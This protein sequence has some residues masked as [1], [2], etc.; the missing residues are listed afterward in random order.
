ME[1]SE[2]LPL[3]PGGT[4]SAHRAIA[5]LIFLLTYLC[6]GYFFQSGQHNEAARFD[7]VRAIVEFQALNIER[8][9]MNTADVI[10]HNGHVYPNKAPGL[11]YLSVPVWI[12]SYWALASVGVTKPYIDNWTCY[13]VSWNT[14]GLAS[15]I[16][17]T[18][19]YFVAFR[20]IRS[21]YI[22]MALTLAYAIGTIAF[23]FSTL[24]FSHQFCAALVLISFAI[25]FLRKGDPPPT[26][27]KGEAPYLLSG[28]LLS[29]AVASEYPVVLAAAP[30]ALYALIVLGFRRSFW[31]F[32]L[33]NVVGIAILISYNF[34]AF[35]KLYYIP[36]SSY[37]ESGEV[38]E[39]HKKGYMGVGKPTLNALLEI[40]F[41]VQRGLF[42]V[43]PWLVLLLPALAAPAFVKPFRKELLLSMVIVVAFF[44]FN[45][46]Y[47]DSIVFWGGGASVGPR[48]IIPMLPFAAILIAPLLKIAPVR[49]FFYPLALFS[50]AVMIVA[51]AVEPRVPYDY[52]NPLIDLFWRDYLRGDFASFHEGVFG[53]TALTM[54]TVAFNLG[55]LIAI[56]GAAQLFPILF[57]IFAGVAYLVRD[58]LVA[59]GKIGAESGILR[60]WRTK[61]FGV[62]LLVFGAIPA[63]AHFRDRLVR[64]TSHGLMAT[65]FKGNPWPTLPK[66]FVPTYGGPSQVVDVR[67]DSQ[68]FIPFEEGRDLGEIAVEWS[69][70]IIIETEGYYS[71]AAESDDGSAVY[72]NDELILDNWG[73]HGRKVERTN[74]YLKAGTFPFGVRYYNTSPGGMMALLWT[75]PIGHLKVIPTRNFILSSTFPQRGE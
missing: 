69:G 6:Y 27:L 40:T 12:V 36:Y 13:L 74:V 70:S 32:A 31:I 21:S 54:N 19:L 47:G 26:S 72:L 2:K 73:V 11:T 56:P 23:P 3:S 64:P 43:N 55:K 28:V 49:W 59:D 48:H 75:E 42:V 58:T 53:S 16:A 51:T 1:A 39:E 44:I 29:V 71:F 10:T 41:K 34:L 37:A 57:L 9:A 15:A 14:V 60:P 8:F 18:M 24:Y 22:S 67:A 33:G 17:A 35:G 7:Q 25:I 63:A 50:G 52:G 61:I 46:G 20:I 68:V 62:L 38:F 4:V 65:Y 45:A 5:R 30:I 66:R